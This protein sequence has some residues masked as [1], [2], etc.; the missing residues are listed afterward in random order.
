MN[1]PEITFEKFCTLI[2]RV[3]SKYLNPMMNIINEWG[4]NCTET[5]CISHDSPLYNSKYTNQSHEFLM[6]CEYNGVGVLPSFIMS[7]PI[8]SI[9]PSHEVLATIN[10]MFSDHLN[11]A[12]IFT[13]PQPT[14]DTFYFDTDSKSILRHLDKAA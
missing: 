8:K 5:I 9:I 14:G 6:I 13:T 4:F 7:Q 11:K 2:V 10:N 1:I 3:L 12:F